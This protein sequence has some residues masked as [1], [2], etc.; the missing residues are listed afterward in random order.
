MI[1]FADEQ[2]PLRVLV[3]PLPGQVERALRILDPKPYVNAMRRAI[4]KTA[5]PHGVA[6]IGRIVVETLN[7]SVTDAKKTVTVKE[8]TNNELTATLTVGRKAISLEKFPTKQLKA[9]A[10]VR[11][12]K[13][14]PAQMLKSAFKRG[15]GRVPVVERKLTAGP[16]SKRVGRG[17]FTFRYGPNVITAIA[18]NKR[19]EGDIGR[20]EDDLS[21]TLAKNI[22]SQI[23]FEQSKMIYA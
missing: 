21:E 3:K 8:A 20:I 13:D 11:V 10:S 4:N 17:P 2:T 19:H 15:I 12:W 6:A 16:G 1:G 23:D 9:G 7:I 22:D 5:K 14:Q 18:G